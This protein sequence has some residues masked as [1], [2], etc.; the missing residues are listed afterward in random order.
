[1]AFV[2]LTTIGVAKGTVANPSPAD[3]WAEAGS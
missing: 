1:M 2:V 3:A